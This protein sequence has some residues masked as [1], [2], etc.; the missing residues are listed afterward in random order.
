MS[1]DYD[2]DDDASEGSR[3]GQEMWALLEG[4]DSGVQGV[5]LGDCVATWIASHRIDG[6]PEAQNA[7]RFQLLQNLVS[8]VSDMLAVAD[9]EIDDQMRRGMQ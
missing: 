2:V 3:L 1:D 8:F 5:A 7:L 9:A 6:D 4:Q